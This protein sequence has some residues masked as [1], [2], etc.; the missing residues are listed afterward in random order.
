MLKRK[1]EEVVDIAKFVEQSTILPAEL[2]DSIIKK[3]KK[4]TTNLEEILTVKN[5]V[6]SIFD[7]IKNT[8]KYK[9]T[10]QSVLPDNNDPIIVKRLLKVLEYVV[11]SLPQYYG[12]VPYRD[13]DY[14]NT[15]P[16]F[17]GG[18]LGTADTRLH[19]N[20]GKTRNMPLGISS[21][22]MLDLIT[23]ELKIYIDGTTVSTDYRYKNIERLLRCSKRFNNFNSRI[24]LPM[25]ITLTDNLFNE[26]FPNDNGKQLTYN[27]IVALLLN[28]ES[29]L[30]IIKKDRDTWLE[31]EG[32]YN[33]SKTEELKKQAF[34]NLSKN[35]NYLLTHLFSKKNAIAGFFENITGKETPEKK[36][37][38]DGRTITINE[39]SWKN[40][41]KFLES[42]DKN[43]T[44][45]ITEL[46][47]EKIVLKKNNL[48]NQALL[49]EVTSIMMANMIVNMMMKMMIRD[50]L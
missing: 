37:N 1:K 20:N 18:I 47:K 12:E 44:T 23:N 30:E 8:N 46:T 48:V 45:F 35:I 15:G 14:K 40:E 33:K 11:E 6:E 24:I 34:K 28:G 10:D 49:W 38:S 7:I 5:F 41:K 31:I 25:F 21:K 27:E 32:F 17:L 39:Y 29:I 50:P 36:L 42:L 16:G 13:R 2:F 43:L 4:A 22:D 19:D 9:K 26:T 3:D